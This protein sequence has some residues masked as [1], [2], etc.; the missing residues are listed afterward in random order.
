[1]MLIY[2]RNVDIT[3]DKIECL[4]GAN[5]DFALEANAEGKPDTAAGILFMSRNQNSGRIRNIIRSNKLYED[6]EKFKRL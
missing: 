3:K 4:L 5:K 6:V 2:C 1:M